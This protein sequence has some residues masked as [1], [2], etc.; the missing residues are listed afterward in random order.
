MKTILGFDQEDARFIFNIWRTNL[1]DRYLGSVLGAIWAILN[2]LIMFALFTFVFAFVFKARIPG[3]D[4]SLSYSIWLICGYGPWLANSEALM[5]SSNAIISNSGLVKNMAF[6]TEVLPIASTLIG[7]VPL[8]VS[9]IFLVILQFFNGEGFSWSLVWLPFV[10]FVQFLFLTALGFLL[11]VITTFVRDFGI[12]LPNLLLICLFGTP[13]FYSIETL[14]TVVQNIEA[15]NPFYIIS[16]AYRSVLLGHQSPNL[17]AI[18]SLGAI[19]WGLIIFN[20]KI[21][22]RIKGFFAS[23]I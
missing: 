12:L 8:G 1:A 2:P 13:I 16:E 10:I 15:F 22:R 18:I 14:P 20:L 9:L 17:V 3:A 11:A 23:I 19:S 21:F 7:V 4:S 6:K 5:A